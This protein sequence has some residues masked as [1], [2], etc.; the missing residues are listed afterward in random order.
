MVD[1]IGQPSATAKRL[2]RLR[3]FRRVNS[4]QTVSDKK[5]FLASN[6]HSA[7]QLAAGMSSKVKKMP[8]PTLFAPSSEGDSSRFAVTVS[9]LDDTNSIALGEQIGGLLDQCKQNVEIDLGAVEYICS[10]A[11]AKIL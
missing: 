8:S 2:G 5:Q 6:S 7:H 3:I 9:E 4:L 11:I 1:S 10:T